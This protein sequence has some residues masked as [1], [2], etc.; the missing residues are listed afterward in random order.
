M[1]DANAAVVGVFKGGTNVQ[2]PFFYRMY[3]PVT[4]FR[5]SSFGLLCDLICRE[6]VRFYIEKLTGL[7]I[8]VGSGLLFC[9]KIRKV[10]QMR[11]RCLACK[12]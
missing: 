9:M 4:H 12:T 11:H 6:I 3:E 10:A 2:L 8:K 1:L 7:E 5:K